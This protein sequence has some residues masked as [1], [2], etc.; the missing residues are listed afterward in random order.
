MD[1]LIERLNENGLIDEQ[2]NIILEKYE[3]GSYQAVDRETFTGFFGTTDYSYLQLA[4]A[5]QGK[6]YT[7]FFDAW[8]ELGIV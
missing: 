1:S 4:A 3:N 7:R 5:D 2:G 6:G 8:H